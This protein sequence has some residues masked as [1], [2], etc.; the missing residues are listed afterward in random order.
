M[1][2]ALRKEVVRQP[3]VW[4]RAPVMTALTTGKFLR[5]I[6]SQKG[7]SMRQVMDRSEGMLDKTTISRIE[8]DD[9]KLSL[10]AAYAFSRIYRI[11]MAELVEMDLG[12]RIP[13]GEAPFAVSPEE[14]KMMQSCRALDRRRREMVHEIVAA[15]GAVYGGGEDPRRRVGRPRGSG[16]SSGGGSGLSCA[17]SD[18]ES[19]IAPEYVMASPE[20]EYRIL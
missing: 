5:N 2:A 13:A 3:H 14:K 17:G 12:F 4:F 11:N 7:M 19:G 6:R 16:K 9:R 10:K 20:E 18:S 15:L 8:N 1:G